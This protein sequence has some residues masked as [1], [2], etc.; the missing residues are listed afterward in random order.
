MNSIRIAVVLCAA[1]VARSGAHHPKTHTP[2]PAP[3][4]AGSR[5]W[6]GTLAYRVSMRGDT[7]GADTAVISVR[8]GQL[9]SVDHMH[10]AGMTAAV[11][12]RM[13]LDGLAPVSLADTRAMGANRAEAR[14]TYADGRVRGTM[15][16]GPASVAIDTALA[17]G[18][19][20]MAGVASVL[21]ALPLRAGADWTLDAYSPYVR[22]VVPLRVT[23]DAV[24]T[25]QT[26]MGPVRAFPVRVSGGPAEMRY[27]FSEAEPRWEVKGEIPA[28]GIV[29]EARSR[30][31]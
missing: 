2:E 16:M 10:L 27:W 21:Q 22:A 7:T 19:Y 14:V 17:A 18:T 5:L 12:T 13:T 25:L 11:E 9:S 1:V 8:D 30:T 4:P 20:D 6:R 28:Y 31:P 26:P 29:I 23:V 3:K 24:E 15:Q